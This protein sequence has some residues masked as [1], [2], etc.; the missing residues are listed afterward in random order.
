MENSFKQV[1]LSNV[2]YNPD[3]HRAQVISENDE[4]AEEILSHKEVKSFRSN[5]VLDLDN[6]MKNE[7]AESDTYSVTIPVVTKD[8]K[9]VKFLIAYVNPK[10]ETTTN[11]LLTI[12]K[13]QD[14]TTTYVISDLDGTNQSQTRLDVNFNKVD[15]KETKLVKSQGFVDCIQE[16][17]NALPWWLK[18]A[19][20][21]S[22]GTCFGIVGPACAAC[23]GCIGGNARFCL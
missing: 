20:T 3:L 5:N 13:N 16:E 9:I 1:A 4:L 15:R 23:A 7:Y 14:S 18:A 12:K 8:E 6:I 11:K 10:S 17:F 22:C 19:C 2:R 21:G